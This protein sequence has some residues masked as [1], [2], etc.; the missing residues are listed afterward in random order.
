MI[1]ATRVFGNFSQEPAIRNLIIEKR[2]HELL[3]LFLENDDM[4]VVWTACGVLMNLMADVR[5]RHVL[6]G[7]DPIQ[8]ITLI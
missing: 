8:S 3:L 2:I 7:T 5:C 4:E 6:K 1:E